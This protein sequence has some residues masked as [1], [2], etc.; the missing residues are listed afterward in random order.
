MRTAALLL[1]ATI[2]TGCSHS[3]LEGTWVLDSRVLPDG[4][5]QESPAVMGCLTYTADHRNFNV[6][7]MDEQ[8]QPVSIS[9]IARYSL[10][11]DEYRETNKYYMLNGMGQGVQYDVSNET[12]SSPVH[13]EGG[14][15][16]FQFPLHGEPAVVFEGDRF[17]ATEE[18]VF[19]DHWRRVD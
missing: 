8:G 1:T 4:T 12:A 3:A 17:T 14:R 19:V 16:S 6:Y 15:M 7:W 2:L 5:V 9:S 11:D 10:T 18:G 13:R